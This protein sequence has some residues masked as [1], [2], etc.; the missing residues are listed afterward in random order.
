MDEEQAVALR[1]EALRGQSLY[2][3]D[4]SRRVT[5]AGNT[6]NGI[7]LALE[8]LPR[9]MASPDRPYVIKA[10]AALY[11]A[12]SA[13]RERSGSMVAAFGHLDTCG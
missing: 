5:A 12:L 4:L 3:A 2:L 1:N 6:T 11:E 13:N 10:E 7:L 8:A 9:D